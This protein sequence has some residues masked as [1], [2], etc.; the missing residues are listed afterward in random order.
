MEKNC[1]KEDL[2]MLA[3]RLNTMD[4]EAFRDLA[5]KKGTTVSRM[6]SNYIKI[7]VNEAVNDPN[8]TGTNVAVLTYKN[9]DRLKHEVAFHNPNHLNPDEMLNHI[10]NQYFKMVAEVRKTTN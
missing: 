2:T 9:V 10:L 4:A 6:L 8:P 1:K 7:A 5:E 3:T